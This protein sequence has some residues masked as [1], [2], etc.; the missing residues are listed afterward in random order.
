VLGREV[1]GGWQRVQRDGPLAMSV[2][3]KD[4]RTAFEWA[5]SGD[6]GWREGANTGLA[7]EGGLK[8]KKGGEGGNP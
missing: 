3:S 2:R 1:G 6:N 4:G 8:A 5:P 7:K